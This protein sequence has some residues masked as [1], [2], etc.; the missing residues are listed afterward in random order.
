MPY[1]GPNRRGLRRTPE[2]GHVGA[3]WHRPKGRRPGRSW[4][5][6]CLGWLKQILVSVAW[7]EGRWG[8]SWQTL[9]GFALITSEVSEYMSTWQCRPR[10][11]SQA[12]DGMSVAHMVGRGGV[13]AM[14]GVLIQRFYL[15]FGRRSKLS[16][17]IRIVSVF[18][19]GQVP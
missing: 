9:P 14:F 13:G 11:G 7:W 6:C 8:S 17:Q 15:W 19:L 18:P 4:P 3:P 16:I 5:G 12:S 10:T 1:K 2:S